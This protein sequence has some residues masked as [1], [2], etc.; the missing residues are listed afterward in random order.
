MPMSG[1]LIHCF[2][3]YVII[4]FLFLARSFITMVGLLVVVTLG[5]YKVM[6]INKVKSKKFIEVNC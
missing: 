1:L 2:N 6:A 5:A 4:L 3:L